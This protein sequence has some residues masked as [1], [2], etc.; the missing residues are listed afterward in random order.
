MRLLTYILA[1][2]LMVSASQ[3]QEAPQSG[4]TRETPP[5]EDAGLI[6][7]LEAIDA[8]GAAITDLTANF[9]QIKH[10]PLL[11]KPLVSSG[12]LRVKGSVVRWE[13]TKPE[14]STMRIDERELRIFYPKQSVVEAY[15]I[16]ADMRR[17]TASPLPRLAAIRS[18]FFIS[19]VDVKELDPAAS[20]D[21]AIGMLLTPK[22]D[23]LKEHVA[24]VRVLIDIAS[25]CAT[26][27]EITDPD[28]ERTEIVFS[29]MRTNTG[30]KDS[31]LALEVPSG[32]KVVHLLEGASSRATP[33]PEGGKP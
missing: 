1:V 10:T 31:D 6:K 30:L 17:M 33:T 23:S 11:K 32:V 9:E 20:N 25:A 29:R 3:A 8:R 13:T 22:S 26:R 15:P 28:G 21:G 7:R 24:T 27:V 14:P 12:T 4:A 18:E 19:G 2:L 16:A 5:V